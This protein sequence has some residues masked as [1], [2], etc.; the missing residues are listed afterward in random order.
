MI[1]TDHHAAKR[2]RDDGW[3]VIVATA[4]VCSVVPCAASIPVADAA[5]ERQL[6]QAQFQLLPELLVQL[7]LELALRLPELPLLAQMLRQPELALQPQVRSQLPQVRLRLL[8]LLLQPQVRRQLPELLLL[9]RRQPELAL[10]PQVRR[11]LPE[12]VL[13]RPLELAQRLA[14]VVRRVW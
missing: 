4:L 11:Q 12:L 14:L 6:E 9:V 3:Q 8:A 13:Q 7:Q 2:L 5:S 1:K 10:Q